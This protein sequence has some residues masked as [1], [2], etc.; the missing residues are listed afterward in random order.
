MI[1]S[2]GK[3]TLSFLG[4]YLILGFLTII[5]FSE[6]EKWSGT[7]RYAFQVAGCIADCHRNVSVFF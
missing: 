3:V 6:D 4:I 5:V 2:R 7:K 1:A